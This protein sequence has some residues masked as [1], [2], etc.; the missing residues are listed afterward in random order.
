MAVDGLGCY[1]DDDPACAYRGAD[2]DASTDCHALAQ[3]AVLDYT[4]AAKI[5][6]DD[7]VAYDGFGDRSMAADGDIIV[8]GAYMAS[9]CRTSSPTGAPNPRPTGGSGDEDED[10]DDYYYYGDDCRA[11]GAVYLFRTTDGGIT[12][13]Q[14]AKLTASDPAANDRFGFSVA[15]D[16]NTI[17]IGPITTRRRHGRGLRLP[18]ERRRRHIRRDCQADGRRRR[19]ATTSATPWPSTATPSWSGP[20]TTTTAAPARARSTSSISSDGGARR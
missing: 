11:S 13:A 16:G 8:V 4:Q 17:V 15:I 6:A 18:H 19:G 3:K 1:V 10:E 5:I 12:Y 20:T 7:G 9:G 14:V 2:H